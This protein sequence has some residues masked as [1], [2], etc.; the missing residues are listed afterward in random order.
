M[1]SQ[2]MIFG[3]LRGVRESRLVDLHRYTLP[4]I[5]ANTP[6]VSH[7]GRVHHCHFG[8]QFIARLRDA[9]LT[10]IDS[11]LA[12]NHCIALAY[13][14][15]SKQFCRTTLDCAKARAR[16]ASSH[17]GRITCKSISC[18]MLQVHDDHPNSR[19]DCSSSQWPRGRTV[20]WPS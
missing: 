9:S 3:E 16:T 11:H 10:G 17:L 12:A 5:A 14:I 1:L 2:A 6:A 18:Q 8:S 19:N 13:I 7:A 15:N 20:S 4:Y